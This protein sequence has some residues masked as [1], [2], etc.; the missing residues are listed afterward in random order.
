MHELL[1]TGAIPNVM[2]TK[3][4]KKLKLEIAPT[5]RRIIVAEGTRSSSSVTPR[6]LRC[7]LKWIGDFTH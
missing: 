1:D 6:K 7:E 4:A 5:D 3:L 2:T